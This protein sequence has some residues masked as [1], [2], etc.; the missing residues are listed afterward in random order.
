MASPEKDAAES[1]F[2]ASR[3]ALKGVKSAL[4]AVAPMPALNLPWNCP[5]PYCEDPHNPAS[6]PVDGVIRCHSCGWEQ[7]VKARE[8]ENLDDWPDL[9]TPI[10]PTKE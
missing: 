6:T 8:P 3:P 9:F 4:S 1:R 2:A 7:K 10:E 5:N